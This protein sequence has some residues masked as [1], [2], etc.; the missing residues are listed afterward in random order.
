MRWIGPA[1]VVAFFCLAGGLV[2]AQS[3][4]TV[5][6]FNRDVRPILSERCFGC[7]GPDQSKRK[8]DL[9]LDTKDGLFDELDEST[10][11]VPR[12]PDESGIIERITSDDAEL[13]MP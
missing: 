4:P 5:V 13:R 1:G 2:R 9:R 11:V 8:A 12:K 7:H 10:P 6:D 3:P